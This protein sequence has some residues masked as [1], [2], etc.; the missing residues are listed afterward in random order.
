[1]KNTIPQEIC[2]FIQNNHVVSIACQADEQLWSASCFYAFDAVN[3]RL[4]ILTSQNTQHGSLMQKYP[5]IAG[6]IAGQPCLIS[7]IE[8]VQFQ[9]IA[10]ILP[11][12]EQ[13]EALA[14]YY[15]RHAYAQS[16]TSDVWQIRF[17]RIKYTSNKISFAEKLEWLS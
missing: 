4:I 1:M 7:D 12:N 5:K 3:N 14:I 13:E 10:Q 6:T 16:M 9:A 17:T 8:G 15:R 11:K 2:T